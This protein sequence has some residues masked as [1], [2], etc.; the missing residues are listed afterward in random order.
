MKSHEIEQYANAVF[1]FC[2]RRLNNIEDACDLSQEILCEALKGWSQAQHPEAW[3]WQIARNRYSR[4]IRIQK[5]HTVLLDDG[6]LLDTLACEN[7]GNELTEEKQAVFDALHSLAASHRQIMVD[8]YVNRLSCEQIAAQ[9]GLACTTVRSRLFYG[10]HKLRKRWLNKME[11][12]RIYSPQEWFVT[13]NGDVDPSLLD[14]Q[15]VRSIVQAC[16]E[17]PLTIEDI[18]LQTGIPCLYVEDEVPKLL[19]HEILH[20]H[21][22][23][24]R[25]ALVLYHENFS[26]QAEK[27]LLQHAAALA[28]QTSA[29]LKEAMPAIRTIGFYGNDLPEKRLWWCLIP[30]LLRE[31]CSLT[32]MQSPDLIRGHFPHRKDGSRGWL[33]AYASPKGARNWFSGCNAYYLEGSRFRYY[34]SK[35]LF[36]SELN[37]LLRKLETVVP[38]GYPP[39]F[40]EEQLAECIRCDLAIH[41][42]GKVRWNT[43]VLTGEQAEKLQGLLSWLAVPLVEQLQPPAQELHE[44]MK[45]EIPP[46]LHGQIRGIFGIEFNSIIDMVC[47]E[48]MQSGVLETP[49]VDCFAGQVIM[50]APNL[51]SFKP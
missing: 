10:R 32:R 34:W 17:H 18:S 20:K 47:H 9:S 14:R 50:L 40:G 41:Q 24:F 19:A 12:N 29:L 42:N 25:T 21:G 48:L 2:L 45:K 28:H 23:R 37:Q 1:G 36:S 35:S 46:H 4:H 26:Q 43:P 6:G 31:A 49:T 44:L 13:G 51:P 8:F 15:V 38:Y 7:P 30:M 16:Y 22:E 27:L 33:C 39:F 5:E 3:L 11:E